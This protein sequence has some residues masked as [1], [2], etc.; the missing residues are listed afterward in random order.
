MGDS[1]P[2]GSPVV[3]AEFAVVTDVDDSETP[4]EPLEPPGAFMPGTGAFGTISAF[5]KANGD[6][7]DASRPPP[8]A[9]P[10]A[11]PALAAD[12]TANLLHP[13]LSALPKAPVLAAQQV[14]VQPPALP[15]QSQQVV[16]AQS[17]P[18]TVQQAVASKATGLWTHDAN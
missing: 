2:E 18:L 15:A 1:K 13:G 17:V 7:G 14:A 10:G 8:E 6:Q 3:D 11:P 5:T 9:T 16:T 12:L 4:D